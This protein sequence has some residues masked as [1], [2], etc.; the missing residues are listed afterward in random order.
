MYHRDLKPENILLA[1]LGGRAI[2]ADFGLSTRRAQSVDFATGSPAYMSPGESFCGVVV[3]A[4]RSLLAVRMS[5]TTS[6]RTAV[7]PNG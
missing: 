4:Q 5:G 7:L 6:L 1:D 3:Y 2:L